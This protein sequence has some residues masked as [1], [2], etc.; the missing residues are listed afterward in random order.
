MEIHY[1]SAL[2]LER[3]YGDGT[4]SPVEVVDALLE[5]IDTLEPALSAFITLTPDLARSQARAAEAALRS[6]DRVGPLCGIPLS[7]KDMLVTEGVRTTSGSKL[8]EDWVPD[9]DSPVSQRVREAGAV[10]LGKSNTPEFG[11]KGVT[12]NL[13]TEPARNPWDL[14]RTPGGSSGG[15]S[16]AVAAGLGPLAHGSDGAGSIRIPSSYS[17]V[18][19]LK[20]SCGLVPAW[21]ASAVGPLSHQG[22]MARTVRDAALMLG[23][24]AGADARDR[25]SFGE[26][27]I[28]YVSGLEAG[29][30]GLR[31]AY[32]PDLGHVTVDAEVAQLVAQAAEQFEA[33]GC[34]VEEATPPG[35]DPYPA[36]D[37][38]WATANAAP[39]VD[40]LDD[41][42][43][44][45]DPG[46]VEVIEAGL[47][48]SGAE[49]AGAHIVINAFYDSM[50]EFMEGCDL[51]LT[52]T[53]P[54]TAFEIGLDRPRDTP[55]SRSGLHWTPFTYPFNVT[56]QPA[57]SVPC[58]FTSDGLPV[59]LQIVG[60]WR[61]DLTVLS[62]AAAYEEAHP[63][64]DR[65]PD[66]SAHGG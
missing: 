38:V 27:G 7:L 40:D 9:F 53:M 5:R 19:G 65:R 60:R 11:W 1:L 26:R 50:R 52:P 56:G 21:P 17:G 46:R 3:H 59:G 58:G 25:I 57:A 47:R 28:D 6:N 8:R 45:I 23:A 54:T 33:L 32:S 44:R 48:V 16:C 34:S 61:D 49:L 29:V 43:E 14:E 13:L 2:E 30:E 51:L 12:S 22:P 31:I 36:L 64:V 62:A 63:W 41:V 42:R 15:A 20:P 66:L 37:L 24:I 10:V 18:F 39:Y 55:P 35:G 4:L